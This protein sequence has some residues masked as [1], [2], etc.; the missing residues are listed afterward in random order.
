MKRILPLLALA[1]LLMVISSAG[2][3]AAG[4]PYLVAESAILMDYTTGE[5][6]FQKN[7]D[8]RRPPA[9]TTKIITAL[10]ALEHGDLKQP[11]IATQ[12]AS[13]AEGSSI[14]LAKG[15]KHNMEDMLYGLLLS[16]GNDAAISLA[17]NLAGSESKFAGWM[18]EKAKALGATSSQF[19]N[20]SGLPETG[21]Y[22]TVHDMAL[23]TRYALH[24]PIFNAIV[25]TKKRN[26]DWPN[27]EYDRTM[28]NHNKLLWRYEYADGVKTGYTREAGRCLVASATRSGHRLIS[29]VFNS[30]KMY[31]DTEALFNYGF[32]NFQLITLVSPK[33]KV[34]EVE[35][36]SG[37]EKQVPVLPHRSLTLLLPKGAEEDLTVNLELPSQVEAPVERMQQVGEIKVHLGDKIIEK[38]PVVTAADVPKK[39]ILQLFWDW[40]TNLIQNEG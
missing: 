34:G 18:T 16:S 24:N 7:A 15:E 8:L 32:N 3:H 2:A 40:V 35:V 14:W 23:I 25:R 31:E 28:I 27:H 20:S 22:T 39:G 4:P 6:L 37:I 11:I 30:K 26:M 36:N 1:C 33:E 38:V 10:V 17:E 5:V 12:A 13:K 19:K 21:H 9:S 29:V